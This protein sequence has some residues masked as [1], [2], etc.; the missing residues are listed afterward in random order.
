MMQEGI[1]FL[2]ACMT[3]IFAKEKIQA[4]YGDLIK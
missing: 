3:L 1:G 4:K 2:H